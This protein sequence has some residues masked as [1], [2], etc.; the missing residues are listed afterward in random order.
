MELGLPLTGITKEN[1]PLPNLA[2]ALATMRR[3]LINGKGFIRR[4]L[5]H[6]Y[7]LFASPSISSEMAII[8]CTGRTPR[9]LTDPQYYSVQRVPCRQMG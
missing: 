1:F 5:L 4:W 7:P 9:T 8:K 3:E 2:P 6:Y